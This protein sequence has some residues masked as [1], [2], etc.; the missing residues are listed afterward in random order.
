[1]TRA[2]ILLLAL[3]ACARPHA[4]DAT[5]LRVQ[6]ASMRHAIAAYHAQQGHP[7]RALGDLVA[8]HLLPAIPVDPIT[9]S[10]STWKSDTE[11]TV[12]VNEDFA[13]G[14]R[15][16]APAPAGIVDVHSGAPGRD[17]AG[18]PWAEY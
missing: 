11:E 1:M 13:V 2:A 5:L 10:P 9:G 14:A 12:A 6:L 18:K 8:A 3:A 17:D 7:P 15:R 16:G 4:D